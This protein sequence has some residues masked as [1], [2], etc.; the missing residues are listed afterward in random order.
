MKN[1]KIILLCG[2]Q[3]SSWLVYNFI[4]DKY[5]IYKVVIDNPVNKT[6]FVKRR[7]KK[8]GILKVIGQILFSLFISKPLT[9]KSQ[10]RI[11]SI[12][13]NYQYKITPIPEEKKIR[14]FSVND[15]VIISWL[16]EQRPDLI[17]V[18]GTRI[19]SK[20]L[21]NAVGCKLINT[22]VGITPKYRGVHGMYWALV[23]KDLKYSGVTIHF[24]DEHID[25][26]S[27]IYQAQVLPTED[28]NFA[29]YPYLQ[30]C[31]GIQ[32]LDKAIND[33]FNY[34]INLKVGPKESKLWTHPTIWEYI[35]YR[36]KTGIK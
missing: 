11:Y 3:L 6:L 35:Y 13:Q 20:N 34:K 12:I 32:L 33:Y 36:Y 21:I 16:K 27:I 30:I 23:N 22:H 5:G 1:K 24:I 26:G 15:K 18:N 19:I 31:K 28:D 25:T 17:I 8:L 10:D 29:T 9:K 7:I 2:N 14:G 4:N